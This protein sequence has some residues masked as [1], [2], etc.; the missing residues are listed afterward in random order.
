MK[1]IPVVLISVL[2]S[3]CL[4]DS[5]EKL[6]E[7]KEVSANFIKRVNVAGRTAFFQSHAGNLFVR[8]L[9]L[10]GNLSRLRY[11]RGGQLT[12]HVFRCFQVLKRLQQSRC[13][14]LE[15]THFDSG[16]TMVVRLIR[17]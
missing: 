3:S 9:L 2:L 4:T 8:N 14:P 7:S 15:L 16:D 12:I 6:P 5:G 13:H 11:L 10:Q 17:L 1:S